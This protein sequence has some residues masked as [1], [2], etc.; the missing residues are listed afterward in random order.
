MFLRFNLNENDASPTE[1]PLNQITELAFFKK[2][3]SESTK[4]AGASLAFG[5]G[6]VI[7][8]EKIM[9]YKTPFETLKIDRKP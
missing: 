9:V 2:G 1:V 3:T 7:I 6:K 4:I 8:I 5:N